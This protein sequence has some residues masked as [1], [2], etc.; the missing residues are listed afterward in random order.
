MDIND[1]KT[2]VESPGC[3]GVIDSQLNSKNR[4]IAEFPVFTDPAEVRGNSSR[5]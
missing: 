5:F 2:E 3:A 1:Q 4:E